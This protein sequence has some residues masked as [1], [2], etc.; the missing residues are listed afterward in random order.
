[1]N[2]KDRMLIAIKQAGDE[3]GAAYDITEELGIKDEVA[4]QQASNMILMQAKDIYKNLPAEMDFKTPEAP[5]VA[6]EAP[7]KPKE[8]KKEEKTPG[9]APVMES[10]LKAMAEAKPIIPVPGV[11]GQRTLK[12]PIDKAYSAQNHLWICCPICGKSDHLIHQSN[13]AGGKKYQACFDDSCRVWLN[14]G[15]KISEM[16]VTGGKR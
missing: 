4:R 8:A 7:K 2:D 14:D 16:M 5:K 6:Q 13:K 3:F 9:G 1:M 12:V 11:S 10:P 15:G